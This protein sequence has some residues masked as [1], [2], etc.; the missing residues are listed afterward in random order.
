[1]E[2]IARHHADGAALG[3]ASILSKKPRFSAYFSAVTICATKPI[4]TE[5]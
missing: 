4:A 2:M 5:L 1:M 3:K